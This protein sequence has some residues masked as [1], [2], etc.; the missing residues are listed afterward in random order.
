M[1]RER[2]NQGGLDG[3][4][5]GW[6][7][8]APRGAYLALERSRV[9]Q[10]VDDQL[11]WSISCLFVAKRFRRKGLS[12]QLIAA[13]EIR[14]GARGEGRGGYPQVMDGSLPDAFVWTGLEQGFLKAGFVEVARRSPKRPIVRLKM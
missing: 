12:S 6:C 14:K 5:V 8:V 10:P 1:S 3:Q 7:A 4:A 2:R 13:A 9:L 11:V